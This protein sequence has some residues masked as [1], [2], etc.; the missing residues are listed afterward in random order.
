MI[1]LADN[2]KEERSQSLSASAD[3][4]RRFG[5]F[6]IN[7][8]IEGFYTKLSDV[9][10][11]TDGEVVDGVLIRTRHNAPGSSGNG[12]YIGGKKWLI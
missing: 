3:V 1:E 6:Q 11:L 7:F 12:T 4:Y 9:F 2:L 8:L 10:A 5:A